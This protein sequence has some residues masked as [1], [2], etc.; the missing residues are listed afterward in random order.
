MSILKGPVNLFN[1]NKPGTL[2]QW[3]KYILDEKKLYRDNTILELFQ[4][5]RINEIIEYNRRD[6][7]LTF[8]IWRRIQYVLEGEVEFEQ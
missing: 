6:V 8:E 4:M 2:E 7:E 5:G 3:S 1:F